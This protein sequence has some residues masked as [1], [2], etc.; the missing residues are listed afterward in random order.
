MKPRRRRIA[1]MVTS[2]AA[3]LVMSLSCVTTASASSVYLS[4]PIYVQ[5]QSNWCWAATSKSV[6]VYLGG[7]NSSQCQ[8]VKW[9]KN[10]SSCANVTGDLSTDVRRALSSAGIRNTGSMINS[11]ASTATISGQINNSKPL[12]VRWGWDSGGGHMLVI[13]GLPLIR[14]ILLSL[15]SI[16]CSRITAVELTTG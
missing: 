1:A 5:E 11:A 12:M 6:S 16:R 15:T 4:V 10:S 14:A 13:R 2:L 3:A 8:Y 9:G 7:S